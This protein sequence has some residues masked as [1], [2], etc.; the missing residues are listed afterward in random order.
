M[1]KIITDV[2]S[3]ARCGGD[4]TQLEFNPLTKPAFNANLSFEATHWAM[5]P[6]LREPILMVTTD[7]GDPLV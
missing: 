4:H 3:C 5:C 7:V 1:E 2:K 6:N